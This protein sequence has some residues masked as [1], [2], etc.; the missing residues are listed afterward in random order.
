MDTQ[1]EKCIETVEE[2]EWIWYN[3]MDTQVEKCIEKVKEFEWIGCDETV[4]QVANCIEDEAEGL[5]IVP[6]GTRIFA[7]SCSWFHVNM[8]CSA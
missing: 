6:G 3:K 2:F 8:M 5:L 1:V 4:T 7:M